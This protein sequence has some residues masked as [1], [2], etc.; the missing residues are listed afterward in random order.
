[1][2]RIP[3][4]SCGVLLTALLAGCAS[5]PSIEE[6]TRL[7]EYQA[8]LTKQENL[9]QEA[10]QLLV[11]NPTLDLGTRLEP[12]FNNGKPDASTGLI[13]SLETMKK[14]CAKYLP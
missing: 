6:Q 9:Q 1:M 13:T 5:S 4:I 7:M 14:N 3:I 2:N 12:F 8:C 10:L 11:A